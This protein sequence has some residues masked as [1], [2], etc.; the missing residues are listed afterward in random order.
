MK[1]VSRNGTSRVGMCDPARLCGRW[2]GH[3]RASKVHLTM[4]LTVLFLTVLSSGGTA[5]AEPPLA[6][7]A[8]PTVSD[9][10]AVVTGTP[11]ADRIDATSPSVRA[12]YGGEGNDVIYVGPNVEFVEGGGGDDVIYGEPRETGIALEE[13][14]ADQPA[15]P[16]SYEPASSTRFATPA[17]TPIEC[18]YFC[19]GGTGNQEFVG[20]PGA[21]T[22]FGQRGDDTLKGNGGADRLYG[23]IGDDYLYGGPG[24]DLLSGGPGEDRIYGEEGNDLV[25]GDASKDKLFGGMGTNTVSFATATTPGF[26]GNPFPLTGSSLSVE[27]FPEEEKGE[28]RGVY[29][30]LDKQRTSCGALAACNN[31]ARYAGGDDLVEGFQNVIGSPFADI[32]VGSSAN[33]KIYGGGGSDVIVGDGG[34]DEIYGGAESDYLEGSSTSTLYGEGGTDN[35]VNAKAKSSCEGTVATVTLTGANVVSAGL[36]TP[37]NPPFPEDSDAYFVG[38][39]NATSGSGVGNDNVHA[40][41]VFESGKRSV[42]IFNAEESTEFQYTAETETEGCTYSPTEIVCNTYEEPDAL[43]MAAMGGESN[44]LSIANGKFGLITSPTLI[45]GPGKD[46]LY[47]SGQTEDVL[48]DGSGNDSLYGYDYDDFLTNNAGKD[49]LYGGKGDDLLLSMTTCDGDVIN[50]GE[51]M[52]EDIGGLNDA[53][54][55]K[56]PSTEGV[57]ANLE[58]GHAGSYLNAGI[59][60]C[61][62]GMVDTLLNINDLEGSEHND[63]LYGDGGEN[64]L[65]GHHGKDSLY[66]GAGADKLNGIG[67][68]EDLLNGGE[69]PTKETVDTCRYSDEVKITLIGCEIK[70]KQD[71]PYPEA[72]TGSYSQIGTGQS[73]HLFGSV[74]PEGVET[75]FTFEWGTTSEFEETGEFQAAAPIP[76]SSAGTGTSFV[77]VEG[78]AEGLTPGVPYDYRIAASSVCNPEEDPNELCTTYGEVKLLKT[79]E[80]PRVVTA[81]AENVGREQATLAGS[82]NPH[83]SSTMYYFAWG[84]SYSSLPNKTPELSAGAGT[85]SELVHQVLTGLKPG[86]EYFFQIVASN[87][88]GTSRGSIGHLVTSP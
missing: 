53:S 44:V 39:G 70:N 42:T 17:A 62:S 41:Y 34:E 82:V 52:K 54:W 19:E 63:A 58:K 56:L 85:H 27:G 86:H 46:Q 51:P 49:L 6:C 69:G 21:D 5:G 37:K 60:A 29:V 81:P 12:V 4:L 9:A 30:R 7:A 67:G 11:C 47:G 66:G 48:V 64:L 18:E 32:I 59:P 24:N 13:E 10:G 23:G 20:G 40:K 80:P 43:T 65:I 2:T 84:T 38:A 14:E 74:D 36:M 78:V 8:G 72:E 25:R 35:C 16:I 26:E 45:G 68:K 28:R 61:K 73:A 31:H 15:P 76:G 75:E 3:R 33:N 88:G 22:I 79:T 83:G 77:P 71:P 50:G 57:T 55:A 1:P 87:A